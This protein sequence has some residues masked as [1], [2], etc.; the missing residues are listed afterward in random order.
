MEKLIQRILAF[1][2]FGDPIFGGVPRSSQ[3]PTFRKT[4][5]KDHCEVCGKKGTFLKPLELHHVE[6]YNINPSRELDPTNVQ[7]GCRR[8]HQ[9]VY[10]LDNFHSWNIDAQEDAKIL[11]KKIQHRP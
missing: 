7:T 4:H 10:H 1:C 8:C 2:G 5:I 6:P 3:W 11:F 9:L